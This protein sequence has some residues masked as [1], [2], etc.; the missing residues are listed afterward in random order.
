[1]LENKVK[2]LSK[3]CPKCGHTNESDSNFCR[4]CGTDLTTPI[5]ASK[6]KNQ[7][8]FVGSSPQKQQQDGFLCFGEP[9]DVR[10]GA[11]L[12]AVFICLGL[13]IGFV[14]LVPAFIGNFFGGFGEGMGN[15]GSDF[16]D[17]MGNWGETFGESLT[18]FF[19]GIFTDNQWWI[20][21]QFLIPVV[22]IV[23]GIIV[24]LRSR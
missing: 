9:S 22:F 11:I 10:G 24:I 14:I 19:E 13:F 2:K 7:T 16:G 15:L 5:V 6:P 4:S 21:I 17:A 18:F 12:G 20:W 8:E 1:M 23:M 3:V